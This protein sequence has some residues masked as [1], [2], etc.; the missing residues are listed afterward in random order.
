VRPRPGEVL[1]PEGKA[2]VFRVRFTRYLPPRPP[3]T[4]QSVER[5]SVPAVSMGVAIMCSAVRSWLIEGMMVMLFIPVT[6]FASGGEGGEPNVYI[7]N[8][9]PE[10]RPTLGM[11]QTLM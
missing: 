3:F 9:P 2:S 5:P 8:G 1:L 11:I 7:T 4:V 6:G 10:M